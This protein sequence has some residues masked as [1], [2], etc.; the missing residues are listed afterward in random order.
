MRLSTHRVHRSDIL[1]ILKVPLQYLTKREGQP[2]TLSMR[3]EMRTDLGAELC[4]VLGCTDNGKLGR[5]QECLLLFLCAG[6]D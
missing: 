5:G 4:L 6:H 2:I 1:V 3:T